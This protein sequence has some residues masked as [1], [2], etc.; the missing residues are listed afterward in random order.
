MDFTINDELTALRSA[1][2]DML[3]RHQAATTAAV[4]TAAPPQLDATVWKSLAEVGV[5]GLV[6][7]E[8]LGGADAGAEAL[9][10]V[11]LELGAAG[12]QVPLA[13]VV[14]AG[15]ALVQA[16]SVGRAPASVT[17]VVRGIAGGTALPL[18]ALAEPMRVWST[19]AT[20]VTAAPSGDGWS[21]R[22]VKAPVRFAADGTHFVVSAAT[23]QGPALLLVAADAAQVT[24][25]RVEFNDAPAVL[26]ALGDEADVVLRRAL[27]AA[28]VVLCGE[29]SG[30]MQ[31][32]LDMTVEYLNVR[33]QFGRPL[34]AFQALTHRAADM[35][36]EATVAH[37]AALFAAMSY[38][39][40]P[41]DAD[42]ILRAQVIISDAGRLVG[43]EAIQM[44]GGIGVT[45]E[46]R[47]GH[48]TG[49]LTALD[50]MWGSQDERI[51]DLATRI[52]DHPDL[53]VLG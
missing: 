15:T 19:H 38:D 48:Y 26:L 18:P 41:D 25:D 24:T 3:T 1:V 52:S 14:L 50:R 46:H 16:T 27:G 32:A 30:A 6:W 21:V 51:A 28:R 13:E 20:D 47:I 7:P 45:A 22:G 53:A 11:A 36:S 37:S 44:H 49:R 35:Y 42:S 4:P 9:V 12:V 43:Q 31:T 5:L 23:E 17:E 40:D 39:V 34:A 29:S 33:E 8:D 2:K 10:A